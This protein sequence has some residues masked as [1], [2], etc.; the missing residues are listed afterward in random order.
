MGASTSALTAEL[1]A[2]KCSLCG[3]GGAGGRGPWVDAVCRNQN[4]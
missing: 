2:L 4:V 1:F 3:V